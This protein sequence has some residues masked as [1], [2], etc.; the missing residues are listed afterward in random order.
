MN[1]GS[2]VLGLRLK[3]ADRYEPLMRWLPARAVR[4]LARSARRRFR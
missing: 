1:N 4:R 2:T 3:T